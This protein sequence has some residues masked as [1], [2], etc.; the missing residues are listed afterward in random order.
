MPVTSGSVSV[1]PLINRLVEEFT[2]ELVG[3]PIAIGLIVV[4]YIVL[5]RADRRRARQ[6]VVLLVLSILCGPGRF[7]LPKGHTV[8]TGLS[9]A[10]TFLLL[11]SIGRSM[12][13]LLVHFVW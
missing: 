5:P 11:A 13:L 10:A 1:N 2:S 3:V 4:T 9:F 8:H 12:V 6:S 7:L